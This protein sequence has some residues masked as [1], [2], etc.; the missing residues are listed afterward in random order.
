MVFNDISSLLLVVNILLLPVLNYSVYQRY[1]HPVSH[2]VIQL[3]Y[4]YC[5]NYPQE[6][7]P[8]IYHRGKK[9]KGKESQ[10]IDQ[11]PLAEIRISSN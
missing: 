10:H 8:F 9:S 7:Q 5:F 6:F 4:S 11:E 1:Q 3:A 2:K